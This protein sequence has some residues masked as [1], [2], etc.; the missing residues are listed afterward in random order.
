MWRYLPC[1]NE[2]RYK[3]NQSFENGI[4]LLP[5]E[6]NFIPFM[7]HK[8]NFEE[9]QYYGLPIKASSY[10]NIYQEK[11]HTTNFNVFGFNRPQS[12]L[13]LNTWP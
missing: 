8:K 3:R 13:S 10:V 2:E 1:R 5:P 4:K 12:L 7:K 9:L 11:F 6:S